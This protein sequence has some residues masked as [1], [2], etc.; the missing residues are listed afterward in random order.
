MLVWLGIAMLDLP[1]IRTETCSRPWA[2][3]FRLPARG[4]M[5]SSRSVPQRPPRSLR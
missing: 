5:C 1:S 2:D 4:R 3:G